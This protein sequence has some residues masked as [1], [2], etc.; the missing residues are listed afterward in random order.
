MPYVSRRAP[1]RACAHG[2]APANG[3]HDP[4][5]AVLMRAGRCSAPLCVTAH[6]PRRTRGAAS[7]PRVRCA[8]WS[9]PRPP[10]GLPRWRWAAP[11]GGTQR[12]DDVHSLSR[13]SAGAHPPVA[14]D[15]PR[16]PWDRAAYVTGRLAPR[17]PQYSCHPSAGRPGCRLTRNDLANMRCPLRPSDPARRIDAPQGLALPRREREA[18]GE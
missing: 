1:T 17:A 12:A 14:G 18:S 4:P 6:R 3:R 11:P 5:R 16:D 13:V 2:A 15:D 10:S 9:A 7:R 8:G